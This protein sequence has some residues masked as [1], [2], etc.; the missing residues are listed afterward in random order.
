MG[1]RP[2]YGRELCHQL[3]NPGRQPFSTQV[4]CWSLLTCLQI[5][6]PSSSQADGPQYGQVGTALRALAGLV[7]RLLRCRRRLRLP[8]LPLPLLLVTLRLGAGQGFVGTGG[9][10]QCS[11]LSK[12]LLKPS[13]C[14][15]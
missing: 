6:G 4:V 10:Q 9:A 15:A 3:P 8:L 11:V 7:L 12:Q 5:A 1:H 13:G 2:I 14:S